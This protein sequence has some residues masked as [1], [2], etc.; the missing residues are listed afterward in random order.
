MTT[1]LLN[2]AA[3]PVDVPRLVRL[4]SFEVARQCHEAASALYGDSCRW[5]TV[6]DD[7]QTE[8]VKHLEY[9]VAN[10]NVG[11]SE[12]HKLNNP[13]GCEWEDVCPWRKTLAAL[14]VAFGRI[15]GP[16][17]ESTQQLDQC[18]SHA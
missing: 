2:K 16:S 9:R 15:M 4:S 11:I 12:W 1:T 18:S 10:P 3:P 13:N 7:E 5:E 8:A 6:G 17:Y 14:Y